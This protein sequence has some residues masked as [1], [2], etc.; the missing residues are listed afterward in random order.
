MTF[1]D[2][3]KIPISLLVIPMGM[4]LILYRKKESKLLIPVYGYT[5]GWAMLFVVSVPLI[6]M[7]KT[8]ISL[9]TGWIIGS[10][11]LFLCGIVTY[12][13]TKD[14]AEKK[15]KALLSKSEIIY[16]GLFVAVVLF[17]LYKTL[18]F[19]YEDGD[20]AFYVA[21]ANII[22]DDATLYAIEPY[23]GVDAELNYRYAL[24]PFP[25]WV[26]VIS[27]FTGINAAAVSH[28][29]IPFFLILTTYLI[30][31]EIGKLLFE[32]NNEKRYM[33][34]TLIAVYEMFSSVSTSTSGR[35][36]LT[37]ARQGKEALANII[38]PLLFY[39]LFRIIKY[40]CDITFTDWLILV[41]VCT[42]SALTSTFGNILA[43]IMISAMCLYLLIAKK[44]F[45]KAVLTAT[46]VVPNLL[47]VLL[48]MKLS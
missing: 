24:A 46:V 29:V 11:F 12:F 7:K 40:D 36:L 10:I 25:M 28:S 20:D 19:A 5:V 13:A 32:E 17:Q 26:A 3:I 48:Y 30:F 15:E 45:K 14:K 21:L 47:T 9:Y 18:F 8:F 41:L 43:P 44:N 16:L 34:L 33:F 38:L 4:G 37:R 31:N 6:I 23:L 1:L 39:E 42:S 35:F 27:R 22:D 2:I